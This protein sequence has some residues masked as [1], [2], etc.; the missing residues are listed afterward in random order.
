MRAGVVGCGLCI[1]VRPFGRRRHR[2]ERVFL[3]RGAG[4]TCDPGR[5]SNCLYN[6][7]VGSGGACDARERV[8]FFSARAAAAIG[9]R[10]VVASRRRPSTTPLVFLLDVCR[11]M[12]DRRFRLPRRAHALSSLPSLHPSSV[13]CG[14]SVARALGVGRRV[15]AQ[16]CGVALPSAR[17]CWGHGGSHGGG[18]VWAGG[19]S[20]VW[21][22]FGSV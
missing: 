12:R 10:V 6:R 13:R 21:P 14:P 4:H 11:R 8:F 16:R 7:R 5:T 1:C 22:S 17:F 15:L 3:R 18:V 2:R 19:R 9:G 20:A